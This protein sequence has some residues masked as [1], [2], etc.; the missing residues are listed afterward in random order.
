ML[1]YNIIHDFTTLILFIA[2]EKFVAGRSGSCGRQSLWHIVNY[3]I[4]CAES[5]KQ[6]LQFTD[7]IAR[8]TSAFYP[9]FQMFRKALHGR[10][11]IINRQMDV[12]NAGHGLVVQ[13]TNKRRFKRFFRSNIVSG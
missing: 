12:D 3:G 13:R 8:L 11:R 10:R 4:A 7:F 1:Y 9:G 2:A 6:T 5:F